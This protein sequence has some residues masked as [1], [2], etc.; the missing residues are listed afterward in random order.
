MEKLCDINTKEE[1]ANYL[2]IGTQLLTYVLYGKKENELY[3][4]FTIPKK[5]GGERA[6]HAPIKPLKNIQKNLANRLNNYMDYVANENQIINK[7]SHGFIKEKSILTNA[8]VH[9]GKRYVL[10]I[11]LEDFFPSLHFGRVRGFFIHNKYFE[12]KPHIATMI[13]QL[14]CFNRSLPQGAPTSPVISNL[15]ANNLDMNIL[16]ITKKYSLDYTRYVDDLTFST[17]EN[18]FLMRSDDLIAELETIINQSGFKVN[19]NKTRLQHHKSRQ[20]V[21]GLT[22]NE[23]INTKK[24]Y[25]K[26]T[27]AMAH[28]LYTNGHFHIND[29]EGTINQLN[30]RFSFINQ[31][32]WHNNK[33]K[34]KEYDEEIPYFNLNSR[35]KEYQK[36]IFYKN[37][38]NNQPLLITEGKT[39][40]AYLKAAFKNKYREYPKLIE[41]QIIESKFIY[42]V[43]FLNRFNFSNE[44]TN[45]QN[46]WLYFFNFANDG[47]APIDKV[48]E[49][50]I[51]VPIKNQK[52]RFPGYWDFFADLEITPTNPVIIILDNDQELNLFVHRN[53]G[54][55]IT[56]MLETKKLQNTDLS[57]NDLEKKFKQQI[58]DELKQ[59]NY[60]HLFGNIYLLTFPRKNNKYVEIEDLFSSQTIQKYNLFNDPFNKNLKKISDNNKDRFSKHILKNYETVDFKEFEPVLK[61]LEKILKLYNQ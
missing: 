14:T 15:I 54:K 53:H 23:K 43:S 8:K 59:N 7:I 10:N 40:I 11:D 55:I 44:H 52:Y 18:D 60:A 17:S 61:T 42:N 31:L 4:R 49:A 16:R 36:F 47:A 37:F 58:H 1:F 12:V 3:T 35:E 21:T 56:Y 20:S 19:I 25:R 9:R 41:K 48:V 32:D 38:I 45:K 26:N 22:V 50:Y 5:S 2:G 27:R 46:K 51:G 39:D 28:S 33:N 6:I 30:G 13:A 29:E 57:K 34:E 24:E